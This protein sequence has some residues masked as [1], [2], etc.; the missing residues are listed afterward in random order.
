MH[1][2][3]PA[4]LLPQLMSLLMALAAPPAAACGEVVS[5]PGQA[6]TTLRYAFT[7]AR[8]QPQ[9]AIALVLLVG[10]GGHLDLN[11]KGCPRALKGNSLVRMLP[12]FQA[13]GFA[14]ALVDAPS[15]RRGEEGLAGDRLTPEHAQDIGAV[16]ASVRARSGGPVWLVGTSRGTLSAVNAAARPAGPGGPDGLVLA[17]ALMSGDAGARKPWV[18]HTVFD[19]PLESI[20]VPVLLLGH[21]A[22][23]CPRSPVG[24][25]H[26]LA[27]RL[28]SGREDVVVVTGGP[29]PAGVPKG[30]PA[31][32]GRAPHGFV[33]QEVEVAAGIARFVRGG[34][35]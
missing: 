26:D 11:A 4:L 8:S 21:A 34:N 15:N 24:L 20:T 23:R 12:L 25:M 31:C 5:V 3:L 6:R 13:E 29:A 16:I 9:G 19:L 18:A 1:P 30:L 2:L 22:D 32:E 35:Y 10:G 28:Q 14:T 33:D 27:A 17:S 7:P